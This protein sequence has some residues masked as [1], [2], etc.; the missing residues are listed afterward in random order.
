MEHDQVFVDFQFHL[1]SISQSRKKTF[2]NDHLF[3]K[4]TKFF[5]SE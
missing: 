1:E 3:E 5:S 4:I 2:L